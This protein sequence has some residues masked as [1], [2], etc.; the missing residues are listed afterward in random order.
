MLDKYLDSQDVVTNLLLNS[1][2]NNKLSQA[3]LFVCDDID[4]IY[5]LNNTK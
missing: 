5:M 4:Y 2:K 1:I 3:Y